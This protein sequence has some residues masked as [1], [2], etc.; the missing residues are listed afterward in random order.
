MAFIQKSAYM[1]VRL[2]IR[3]KSFM[4]IPIKAFS[5]HIGLRATSKNIYPWLGEKMGT[6]HLIYKKCTL[7][8]KKIKP[9]EA[10]FTFTLI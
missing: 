3:L 7:L 10:S 9:D 2:F 1:Y 4:T 5:N 6:L 8:F